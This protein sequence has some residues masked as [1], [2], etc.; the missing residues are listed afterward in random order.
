MAMI[1]VVDD[2]ADS[3]SLLSTL[4]RL[5]RHHVLEA[6]D[7]REAIDVYRASRPDLVLLDL[8]MPGIDGF[9]TI[10]TLRREFPGSRII[11]AS[12]GWTLGSDDS[13]HTARALG[14]DLTI[15]KPI[16]PEVVCHAVAELLAV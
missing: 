9:E 4:V 1:L 8:F 7:G 11:A 10:R 2:N 16:D 15:R 14:A 3:R 5:E 6:R 13:L 12:A